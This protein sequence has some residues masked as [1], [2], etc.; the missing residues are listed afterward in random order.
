MASILATI[1]GL[2]LTDAVNPCTLAVQTLLLSALLI[3]R[4]RRDALIGGL[5]FTATIYVM[6]FLYGLGILTAIYYTG[7]TSVIRYILLALLVIMIAAEFYAY[8]SYSPGLKSMEMPLKLRPIAQKALM[9][10]KNPIM[11]IPVAVLCSVLLLPCSSGPYLAAI[12]YLAKTTAEKIAYL[13]YYNAIFVLPMLGITLLVS[14]GLSPQRVLQWRERNIR[15]LH[16]VAGLLLTAV[17]ILL[18]A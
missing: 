18:L 15:Y 3:T 9:T 7:L 2:A 1:T 16:L 4:G 11:A 5:L 8:F 12:L 10:T 6:Y 14:F 17:L 13:L